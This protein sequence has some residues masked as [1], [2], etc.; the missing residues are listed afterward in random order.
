MGKRSY[1]CCTDCKKVNEID[2][3]C[4]CGLL[5]V[6]TS[7]NGGNQ[8]QCLDYFSENLNTYITGPAQ[9]RKVMSKLGLEEK[10]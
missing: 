1:K 10:G 5:T 7:R 6:L 8:V 2:T 9:K 3:I 4:E